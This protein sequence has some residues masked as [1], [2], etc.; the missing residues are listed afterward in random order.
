M[1]GHSCECPFIQIIS[2]SN[3]SSAPPPFSI[4]FQNGTMFEKKALTRG[5]P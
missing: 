3:Y 5:T 4:N 1:K 2:D